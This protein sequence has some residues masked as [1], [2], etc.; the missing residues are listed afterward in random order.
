MTEQRVEELREV[1]Y[2]KQYR[3]L[4]S[5]RDRFIKLMEQTT[6]RELR[7]AFIDDPVKL[8]EIIYCYNNDFNFQVSEDFMREIESNI[9]VKE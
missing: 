3:R 8:K 6:Q 7:E 4:V 9:K 5:G 2:G 1:Y